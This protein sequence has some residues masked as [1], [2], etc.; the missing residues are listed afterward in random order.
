M[1]NFDLNPYIRPAFDYS[2]VE[3]AVAG[4][5][6]QAAARI[7]GHEKSAAVEIGR[8][9]IAMKEALPHGQF[10]PWI[11]AELGYSRRTATNLMQV[12]AEFG[13]ETK[14]ATV[15]HLPARVLYQLASPSTPATVR[16][17]VLK[18]KP[19]HYAD[20]TVLAR[21]IKSA[22]K[23]PKA[24]R[25]RELTPEEEAKLARQGEREKRQ[26]AKADAERA[27]AMEFAR[28]IAKIIKAA[29]GDSSPQIGPMLVEVDAWDLGKALIGEFALDQ[30]QAAA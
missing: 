10:I 20:P 15:S 24:R 11:E 5:A 26:V 16:E 7:R 23:P 17:A 3:T 21:T 4:Q 19:G 8:E 13:D 14:W 1:K 2:V 28:H 25:P 6:R 27:A 18:T 9:L 22:R 30:T 29:L 12:A